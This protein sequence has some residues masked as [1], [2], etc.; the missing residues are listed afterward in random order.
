MTTRTNA[1]IA[2]MLSVMV[3]ACATTKETPPIP[4]QPSFGEPV[5]SK[6]I[7]RRATHGIPLT[8]TDT[9]S[10]EDPEVIASLNLSHLSGT[11]TLR[12][13]WYEPTGTLY[14]STGNY[15]LTV[16]EGHYIERGTSWHKIS[17]QGE[18]AQE[19]PGNWKLRLYLDNTPIASKAF[20]L[21][22]PTPPPSA[23]LPA[24]FAR[25]R[26]YAVVVGI[27]HYLHAGKIGLTTLPFADDDAVA[28]YETLL[29]LGWD[30][31]HIRCLVNEQA[32]RRE[33]MVSL[34]SWLTK[35][36][37]DDMILLYWSGHGFPDPENPEKVYFACYDTDPT[38][39]PTGYRMDKVREVLSERNAK[40]VV[41]IADTCHAGK[42][43]TRGS[44]GISVTP[45]VEQLKRERKVP[46]GW[47]FM[48][49]ADTDRQAIEHSSWSN[50]AFTHCLLAALT[51]EADG[52]E[53]VGP[54]D[55]VITMGELRAYLE[56]TMPDETQRVLGVAKRP[57]ITTST[58]DPEIWNLT[59]MMR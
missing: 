22:A 42:L 40:H 31:D 10:T 9:F 44:K 45:Y 19:L 48:V 49:G 12:W 33:I 27:S 2:L 25:R 51:G 29:A 11:H 36:G 4:S 39:P 46:K 37:P 53:S 28:F 43:I 24:S 3:C 26:A 41:I 18:K 50:G 16:S 17:L 58:G 30:D 56:S 15:P 20:T 52:Y 8:P 35:A 59:L 55:G 38:I 21:T 54:A 1:L 5:L 6:G 32:T 57:L 34:E 13:E 14:C 47:I 7:E 23:P